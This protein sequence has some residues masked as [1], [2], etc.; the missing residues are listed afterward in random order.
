MAPT[1]TNKSCNV[2]NRYLMS[3]FGTTTHGNVLLNSMTF[4]CKIPIDSVKYLSCG[5]QCRWV[6]MLLLNLS[7]CW[8]SVILS[9]V[10]SGRDINFCSN[11][12]ASLS[13]MSSGVSVLFSMDSSCITIDDCV[14]H[15][16][17]D[18]GSKGVPKSGWFFLKVKV[19]VESYC[20]ESQHKVS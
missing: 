2:C 5:L 14:D 10:N 6:R 16:M 1:W 3:T 9:G 17:R 7:F 18:N 20:L 8:S 13:I 4:L 15:S 19:M 11:W 12:D